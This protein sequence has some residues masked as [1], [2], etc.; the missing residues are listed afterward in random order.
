MFRLES[1][2]RLGFRFEG[3]GFWEV[4]GL[5]DLRGFGGLGPKGSE[6]R[7]LGV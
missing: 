7:R 2:R 1:F 6:L 5:G 3:L 4:L